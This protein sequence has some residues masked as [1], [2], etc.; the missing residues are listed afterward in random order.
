MIGLLGS[1][2][3]GVTQPMFAII[4]GTVIGILFRPNDPNFDSDLGFWAGM[5]LVLAAGM[6]IGA[7]LQ[8][9]HP[10]LTNPYRAPSSASWARS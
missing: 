8:V 5:F 3:L 10:F 2:I 6:L 4:F 1:A 7:A 9:R